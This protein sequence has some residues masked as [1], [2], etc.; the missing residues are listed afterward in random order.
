MTMIDGMDIAEWL[1]EAIGAEAWEVVVEAAKKSKKE[2]SAL[3]THA[4]KT[5]CDI[6]AGAKD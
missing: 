1:R 6:V 4:I 3:E 2:N 5:F